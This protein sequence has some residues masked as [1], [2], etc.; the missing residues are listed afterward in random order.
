MNAQIEGIVFN[1][2]K[3][4]D[5][6]RSAYSASVSA[7][8]ARQLPTAAESCVVGEAAASSQGGAAKPGGRGPVGRHWVRRLGPI[9]CAVADAEAEQHAQTTPGAAPPG[10]HRPDAAPSAPGRR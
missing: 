7:A 2:A 10:Q 3:V 6:R 1:R 5:I 8:S 4:E 9:A